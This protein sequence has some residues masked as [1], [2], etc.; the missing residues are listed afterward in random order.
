MCFVLQ[1]GYLTIR[2][3]GKSC[4][5]FK[6]VNIAP[7]ICVRIHTHTQTYIYVQWNKSYFSLRKMGLNYPQRVQFLLQIFNYTFCSINTV[8]IRLLWWLSGKE[9]A[10]QCR[11]CSFDAWVGKISWRSK[12]QHTPGLLPGESHGQRN[13]EDC[14]W[15]QLT[16]SF[17]QVK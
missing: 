6:D 16:L 14:S 17:S 3:P 1:G 8:G 11:R 2:L 15:T 13:L 4:L 7:Y 9:N 10:C 5:S 12:W